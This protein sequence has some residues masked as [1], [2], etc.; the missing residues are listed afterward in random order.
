MAISDA[1]TRIVR[2][3]G[4][5]VFSFW[6]LIVKACSTNDKVPL[7]SVRRPYIPLTWN[8]SHKP[9]VQRDITD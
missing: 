2:K 4:R 8:A 7:S 1:M 5:L 3:Y 6:R 9:E